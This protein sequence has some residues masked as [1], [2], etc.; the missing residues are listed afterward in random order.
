MY[1]FCKIIDQEVDKA[2]KKEARFLK[3]QKKEAKKEPQRTH[4]WT[5]LNFIDTW[6]DNHHWDDH[7]V[8]CSMRNS[9]AGRANQN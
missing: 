6:V 9:R 2:A 4:G 8:L 3:K 1:Q 5:V 7:R